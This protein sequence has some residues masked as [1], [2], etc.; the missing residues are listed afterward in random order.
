M[1]FHLLVCL[2]L[3]DSL[4]L[5]DNIAVNFDCRNNS[6]QQPVLGE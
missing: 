2:F 4:S 6:V 5:N 3:F 1:T